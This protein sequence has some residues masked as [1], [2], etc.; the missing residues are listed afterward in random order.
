MVTLTAWH[1]FAVSGAGVPTVDGTNPSTA[2]TKRARKSQSSWDA[3]EKGSKADNQ[4][5]YLSELGK[6]E[7]NINVDHG[8]SLACFS[9]S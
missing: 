8:T 3:K 2:Q 6:Q 1:M 7:Y 9:R 5:D 4:A